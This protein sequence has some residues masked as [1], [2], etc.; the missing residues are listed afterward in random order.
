MLDR[1]R[2]QAS[3][4]H[5]GIDA[6][7]DG[8]ERASLTAMRKP[9]RGGAP[10]AL[11]VLAPVEHLPCELDG[12]AS[13][14]SV[15]FPWGSLLRAV[16]LPDPCILAGIRRLG[17][18]GATFEAVFSY[19]PEREAAEVT[20]LGLPPV[21]KPHLAA[22]YRDAGFELALLESL[23]PADLKPIPSTW[24]HRL[25]HGTPRSAWRLRA[26]AR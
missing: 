17:R 24:A 18:P 6:S 9:A 22:G 20:R 21:S 12:L 25:A 23:S 7:R 2:R 4:L 16:A 19:D 3:A 26:V 1:A 15:L 8:L 14:I 11:F 10:N 13:H 5:I